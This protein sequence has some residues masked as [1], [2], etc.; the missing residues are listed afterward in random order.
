MCPGCVEEV[1]L[2]DDC[3]TLDAQ[4]GEALTQDRAVEPPALLD[5]PCLCSHTL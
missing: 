3:T 2:P 4:Q 1:A 5:A